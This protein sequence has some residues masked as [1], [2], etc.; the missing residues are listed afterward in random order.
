MHYKKIFMPIGGGDE[1]EERIRGAL[2]VVKYFNVHLDILY[3]IPCFDMIHQLPYNLQ[4]EFEKFTKQEEK[5]DVKEFRDIFEKL[6]DDMDINI[7]KSSLKEYPSVHIL[8]Q[9]GDRGNMVEKESKY[10]DLVI[11]AS[12]PNGIAT[13]T[14]EAAVL[15]SGKSVIM[16]PRVMT[17]FN[18]KSIIIGWNNSQEAS[19]AITSS[20]D[21]LKQADKVHIVSSE[22]YSPEKKEL[23]K[24]SSY[25]LEHDINA[26][27]ELVKTTIHPGEAL[28]KAAKNGNYDLIV[29]GAYGHKGLKELMFGGATSFLLKNSDIPV[30]MSH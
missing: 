16:I 27:L 5:I 25:L 19:R 10:Y 23:E 13:R 1:L 29:A 14:F 4:E 11:A 8:Y 21:L 12:P 22:E 30:F 9:H 7:S 28:L 15:H 24:L 26:T 17:K 6:C 18:I 20:L 3:S 2:L